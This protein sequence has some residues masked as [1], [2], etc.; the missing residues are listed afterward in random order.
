VTLYVSLSIDT[1]AHRA[2]GGGIQSC[3]RI[4]DGKQSVPSLIDYVQQIL[5]GHIL[6]KSLVLKAGLDY[7]K[8]LDGIL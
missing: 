5:Y 6:L 2:I 4:L 3:H 1:M 8:L 7:I